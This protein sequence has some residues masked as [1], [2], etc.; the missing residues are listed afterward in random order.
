MEVNMFE[1]RNEKDVMTIVK[2]KGVH[3]IQYWFVDVLGVLK[4]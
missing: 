1:C 4:I 2:D 3:F